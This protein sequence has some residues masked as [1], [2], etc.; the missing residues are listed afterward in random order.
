MFCIFF[1]NIKPA[2]KD[3]SPT[4]PVQFVQL[5]RYRIEVIP[6]NPHCFFFPI[7]IFY[8]PL[9]PKVALL[10]KNDTDLFLLL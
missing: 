3:L 9:D 2:K 7:H 10:A 4:F 6:Q 1:A 8:L 5:L